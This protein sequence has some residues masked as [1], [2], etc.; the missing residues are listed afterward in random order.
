VRLASESAS[1]RSLGLSRKMIRYCLR[2]AVGNVRPRNRRGFRAALVPV[3]AAL[4]C[5]GCNRAAPTSPAL[6]IQF[7]VAPLPARV[8]TITAKFNVANSMAKPVV[9]AQFTTEADMTHAGMSPVFG[10]VE[11]KQSGHYESTLKL[12]MAGDWVILLHGTLPTGEKL[13]RQFELSNV[14]L[15]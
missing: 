2:G 8:G 11:E 5:V 15:N 4:L 13:E 3:A 14:Q 6:T 1:E 10:T 9:G 7:E 12:G